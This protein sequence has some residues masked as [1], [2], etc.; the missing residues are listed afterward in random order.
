MLGSEELLGLAGGET[1][2]TVA[3]WAMVAKGEPSR[4]RFFAGSLASADES[5]SNGW[6]MSSIVLSTVTGPLTLVAFVEPLKKNELCDVNLVDT[7]AVHVKD[8]A[9]DIVD[10]PS[11][12][13]D[14]F[15]P[16]VTGHPRAAGSPSRLR[17]ESSH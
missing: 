1:A 12:T 9:A 3:C 10:A 4:V 7:F 15:G 14:G 5:L 8:A 17:I 2:G 16:V 11:T 13:V 6:G